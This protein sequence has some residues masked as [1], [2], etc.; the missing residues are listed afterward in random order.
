VDYSVEAAELIDLVGECSCP[1]DGGEVPG[2]NSSGA[3][4]RRD[5]F[6]TS[7]LVSPV[8]YDLMALL[9]QQTCRPETEAIR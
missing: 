5:R 1:S 4:C 3:G 8:Q 7:T 6:A 2:D 9:D